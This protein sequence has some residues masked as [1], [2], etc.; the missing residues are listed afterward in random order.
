MVFINSFHAEL[1]VLKVIDIIIFQLLSFSLS[2][3]L[4]PG[5]LLPCLLFLFI[6]SFLEGCSVLR[7]HDELLRG[8]FG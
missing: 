8:Q 2:I 5:Q 6:H 1:I 4:I 3:L 7:V